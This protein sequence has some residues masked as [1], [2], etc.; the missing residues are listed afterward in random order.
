MS[1]HPSLT[2]SLD[3]AGMMR[4]HFETGRSVGPLGP[5]V[6]GHILLRML[7]ARVV[8]DKATVGTPGAPTQRQVEDWTKDIRARRFDSKGRE[9]KPVLE[10]FLRE[11]EETVNA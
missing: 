8:N 11:I 4:I 7:E 2:V 1:V 3:S 10:D 5:N 9:Q 6:L